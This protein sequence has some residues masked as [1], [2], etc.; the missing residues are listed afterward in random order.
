MS[1]MHN[2]T[3]AKG[4]KICILGMG[5]TAH[6]RRLD[7]LRDEYTGGFELWGLNN[8]YATFP[9]ITASRRWDRWFELHSWAYLKA[10]AESPNG[11]N[12]AYFTELAA[13][14]CPV[15]VQ[16]PIPVVGD[17]HVMEFV[18]MA[19]HFDSNYFRGSP[20]WMLMQAL[21]EHDKATCPAERVTHLR[22][23]GIDTIDAEHAGQRSAWAF[24]LGRAV[25][26]GIHLSGT[27]SDFMAH[28]E[29]DQGLIGLADQIG[30]EILAQEAQE[31]ANAEP[32]RDHHQRTLAEDDPFKAAELAIANR[33]EEIENLR[34][35]G[36]E[37]VQQ[38]NKATEGRTS[39]HK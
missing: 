23:F 12:G 13:L 10:W 25:D 32:V 21:Y 29:N 34:E 6:E 38:D 5:T 24:W 7:I 33:L 8:G 16:Q 14:G 15:Y 31:A 27:M 20:S 18:K 22:S 28:G 17:Q 36:T 4:R 2:S 1:N 37:R 30:A 35:A 3:T 9:T 11:N 19:R 26:R 39:W